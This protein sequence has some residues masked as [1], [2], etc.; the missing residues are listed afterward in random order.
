MRI[1]YVVPNY[2][3]DMI[4]GIEWYAYNITRELAKESHEIHVFT[5]ATSK[6]TEQEEEL[7]NVKIHRIKSIGL[8][9]RL[10]YWPN[11]KE[12]LKKYNLDII[13]S[14]D[15]AQPQTWQAVN[16]G[17]INNIPSFILFYDIQSQKKP[18]QFIKQFFLEI[19]DNYF[20]H[21]I[22]NKA[23][24]I[25]TRTKD[26]WQ[27]IKGKGI[28]SNKIKLAPPGITEEELK[29]GNRENFERKYKIKDN[30]I[31]FLGRIRKQ[32]GIFLL[33]DAFKE[34]K[35]EMP[36]AKLVYVGTDDKESDGLKFTPKLKQKIKE[37]NISDV[38]MLGPICGKPKNDAIAACDILVLP[39]STEAF[40]QVFVQAMAQGKPV[41]GTN[42]GGVPY[43]VDHKKDGFL[44]K[45]WDKKMLELYL[46]N[47][48]KNKNLRE[49]MGQYGKAKAPQYSYKILATNIVE[50]CKEHLPS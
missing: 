35:K 4:G 28:S 49:S 19:F 18:R 27:W 7:E 50:Y 11:L 31:L 12:N 33:L 14:F 2:Y 10:K 21:K 40:G 44:I 43:V 16:F 39:S 9:Y 15:Y 38:Y 17:N 5:Q 26:P 32:K 6:A 47:L 3:P 46:I 41:I 20:A 34:I 25:L 13:I 48:L 42:T 24:L 22:L 8:F 23:D 1:G 30:V 36:S 29:P 45:P 37:N